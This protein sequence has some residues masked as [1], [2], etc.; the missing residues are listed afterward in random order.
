MLTLFFTIIFI[1]ELIVAGWIISGII[2]LDKIVL[3]KNQEVLNFQPILKDQ[4]QK[5]KSIIDIAGLSL[6]Y[7][8]TFIA[9]QKENC[10]ILIKKNIIASILFLI[11]KIPGKQIFTIVDLIFAVKK[12]FQ[13]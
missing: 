6:D 9:E 10:V 8:V 3:S 5:T 4:L 1:A 12:I 7:F 11:L 2:K 13:G